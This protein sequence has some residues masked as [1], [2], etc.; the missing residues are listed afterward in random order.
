MG[1]TGACTCD[2][3]RG[4]ATND[5]AHA[6]VRLH[7][8]SP[9]EPHHCSAPGTQVNV[10]ADD[11][12]GTVTVSVFKTPKTSPTA[13]SS[14]TAGLVQA[15]SV[16]TVSRKSLTTSYTSESLVTGVLAVPFKF[17]ISNRATTAG[18]TIGGYVGYRVAFRNWF[19]ITPII[20]GGLA[21]VSTQPAQASAS[22]SSPAPSSNTQTSTGTSLSD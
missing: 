19:T 12:S 5:S 16:Y 10:E 17:H 14:C 21:L 20:G 7:G 15:G 9:S 3:M 18:S 1:G 11:G 4:R 13:P 8:K 22:S 6:R 2:A